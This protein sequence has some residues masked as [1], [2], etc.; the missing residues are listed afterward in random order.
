M[1]ELTVPELL[2]I[3][4]ACAGESEPVA[5]VGEVAEAD[6]AEL[7][8]DSLAVLEAT[9]RVERRF[10]ISLPEDEM[11]EARTPGRFVA[12]VNGRLGAS[13]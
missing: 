4:R 8:Y 10:G 7:G 11:T 6:L 3:L 9:S 13:R 2:E 5:D 12:L 1:S